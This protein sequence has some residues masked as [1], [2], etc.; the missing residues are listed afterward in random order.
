[1][2]GKPVYTSPSKPG[3]GGFEDLECYKMG[4]EIIILAHRLADT[5]PAHEKYDLASQIRRAS[6][7]ITANI[8][9]GYGRYHY[10]D[11]LRFYSIARGSLN[12]TLSHFITARVLKYMT[13]DEFVQA[14][15]LARNA[16]MALN[17][18]MNH[19][20]KQKFGA[21]LFG[22]KVIREEDAEY[23]ASSNPESEE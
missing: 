22:D 9:E 19:V 6:K 11:S 15:K 21:D 4:L 12:E 5:L 8:A 14:Y 2:S 16:E 3:T 1:M 7:S 10:L 23:I 20:R 18:F 13:E 17:G